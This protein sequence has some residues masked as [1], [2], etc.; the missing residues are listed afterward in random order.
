MIL[1]TGASGFLGKILFR[2]FSH[3]TATVGICFTNTSCKGFIRAD[4][5]DTSRLMDVLNDV[6][7]SCIVHS[8]AWRD[9][10]RCE[11]DP[12]G[13]RR[14]H[15]DATAHM[16]EWCAGHGCSM[17]YISTDYVF[18]GTNPPYSE[19]DPV[20][21]VSVYGRTKAEGECAVQAL[22]DYIIAR[23]PLQYGFSQVPDDSFILKVL[24]TLS[25]GEPVELDDY[26]LRY[27]TLSD[28]VAGALLNL[29]GSGYRGTMHLCGRTG[30]TRYEM[31]KI[32]ADVFGFDHS[33]I[34]PAPQPVAQAAARPRDSRLSTERY[35]SL[36]LPPFH[37]FRDGLQCVMNQMQEYGY[38]WK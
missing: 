9:P 11:Q 18:D 8:A 33:R 32:I 19:S 7:P 31:W 24:D 38:E 16:V 27:P 2:V 14:L 29:T 5:T 34:T 20:S 28:D 6:N 21:P 3:R 12:D 25:S 23:I 4:I 13:A 30:A 26:Q 17:V 37:T 22:P 15:V 10:D 35:D 1:L 36:G